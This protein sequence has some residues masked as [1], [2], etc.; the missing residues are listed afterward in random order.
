VIRANVKQSNP[1]Y[2]KQNRNATRV[3][4]CQVHVSPSV[5]ASCS[6]AVGK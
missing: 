6:V 2:T 1:K 4:T 3:P 5:A